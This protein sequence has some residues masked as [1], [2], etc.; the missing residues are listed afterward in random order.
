MYTITNKCTPPLLIRA[1]IPVYPS[2]YTAVPPTP[3][4]WAH[5]KNFKFTIVKTTPYLVYR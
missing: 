4:K 2:S 5:H 3:K 1:N